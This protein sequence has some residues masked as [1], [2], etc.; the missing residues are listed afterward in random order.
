MKTVIIT[1]S[2]GLVG[3]ESAYIF[4]KKG[5]RVIGIDNDFR[6]YFFGKTGSTKWKTQEIKKKLKNYF[7]YSLDIRKKNLL[8]KIFFRYRK[9]VKLI[10]TDLAGHECCNFKKFQ[11]LYLKINN[12]K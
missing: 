11:E 8:E 9:D 1:G 12:F 5:F 10:I 3:S 6:K 7:H 2:A 4:H